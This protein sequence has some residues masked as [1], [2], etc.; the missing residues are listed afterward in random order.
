[1]NGL[2]YLTLSTLAVAALGLLVI[3]L[4]RELFSHEGVRLGERLHTLLY[5]RWAGS[6]DAGKV[7]VQKDDGKTLVAPLL[8]RLERQGANTPSALVLDVATGTGRLP[9]ALLG[10]PRFAGRVVGLDLSAG[11]LRKAGER[12]ARFGGRAVLLQQRARPLPFPDETF[13]AVSCL[14]AVELLADR[15]GHY[16]EF[17]RVLKPGGTLLATRHTGV[18]GRARAVCPPGE[19]ARQLSAAGFERVEISPWWARFDLVWAA[20]P[21]SRND[22]AGC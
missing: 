22:Q 12:L 19:F 15:E 5:D 13:D 9:A 20:R 16:R 6:Y 18:W 11:M 4:W 17:L 2:W 14:E 21:G 3:R 7:K 10:D 1:M 8:V